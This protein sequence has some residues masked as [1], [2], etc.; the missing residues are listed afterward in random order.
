LVS[1]AKMMNDYPKLLVILSSVC[2]AE[3]N[4]HEVERTPTVPP[5]IQPEGLLANFATDDAAVVSV[6]E[7]STPEILGLKVLIPAA[8]DRKVENLKIWGRKI[9]V[10]RVSARKAVNSVASALRALRPRTLV[11][12]VLALKASIQ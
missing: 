3:R 1:I 8:S 10:L 9:S 5:R 6:L 7:V 4:L 12:K 2:F 11:R